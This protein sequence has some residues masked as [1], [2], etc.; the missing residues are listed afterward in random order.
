MPK[1][2][3]QAELKQLFKTKQFQFPENFSKLR[4]KEHKDGGSGG[5]DV[6]EDPATGKLYTFKCH[7]MASHLQEEIISNALYQ[8]AGCPVPDFAVV[9]LIPDCLQSAG[10]PINGVYRLAEYVDANKQQSDDLIKEQ[11]SKHFLLDALLLNWDICVDLKNVILGTDG[12]LYRIDNGGALRYHAKHGL[13]DKEYWFHMIDLENLRN[14]KI[15]KD[16]TS[17]YEHLS[18]EELSR[19]HSELLMHAP[20]LFATLGQL[21]KVFPQHKVEEIAYMLQARLYDLDI[22]LHKTLHPYAMALKNIRAEQEQNSASILPTILV[23]NKSGKKIPCVLLGQ[24]IRHQ[25]YGDFGGS[26]ESSDITLFKAAWREAREETGDA[27]KVT[28]EGLELFPSHDFITGTIEE[29]SIRETKKEDAETKKEPMHTH[30][31]FIIEEDYIS[32]QKLMAHVKKSEYKQEQTDFVYVPIQ[33]LLAA[34]KANE[35]IEQEKQK[36]IFVSYTCPVTQEK[37]QISL[38]PPMVKMLQQLPVQ[39]TLK[40]KLEGLKLGAKRTRSHD[41]TDYSSYMNK[42]NIMNTIDNDYLSLRTLNYG[43]KNVQDIVQEIVYS[44]LEERDKKLRQQVLASS[45]VNRDL[46]KAYVSVSTESKQNRAA[47]KWQVAPPQEAKQSKPT[48]SIAH[49]QMQL[50]NFTEQKPETLVTALYAFG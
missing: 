17:V 1:E 28:A 13:K 31:M 50:H 34:V 23:I 19:Q 10:L 30:R 14:S 21:S 25:W 43:G 27:F 18:I 6:L 8:A 41:N 33:D 20:A 38:F 24:R 3:K 2:S 48:Q 39:E 45:F 29:D 32:P 11:L 12:L 16:A 40:R 5:V 15:N 49:L 42:P 4:L 26:S 36:T 35:V 9:N 22:R 46:K 44:D 47:K 37:K 7:V